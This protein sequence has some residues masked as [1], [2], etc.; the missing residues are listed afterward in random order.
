MSQF[1]AF[2]L[3]TFA[4]S[5]A[6]SHGEDKFGP[7]KGFV[8]MPGAFHTEVVPVS[9]DKIKVF[10]LDMGWE[11]PSIKDSNVVLEIKQA[12]KK[13]LLDCTPA[14]DHYSC[15]LPKGFD[16]KSGTLEL[17]ATRESQKGNLAT[18]ELPLKLH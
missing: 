10:L 5:F 15:K 8:R 4:A 11:N 12:S 6:L 7:H 3:I 17:Q 16:L 1:G 18:Y 2:I 9:K 14:T 13:S